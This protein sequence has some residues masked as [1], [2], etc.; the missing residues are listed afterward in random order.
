MSYYL[1]HEGELLE[2]CGYAC[3]FDT[4]IRHGGQAFSFARGAFSPTLRY[5]AKGVRALVDHR[6]AGEWACTRDGSLRLWQDDTGLAFSANIPNT[7]AGRGL[8]RAVADGYIGCSLHFRP[9]KTEETATGYVVLST[10][11]TEISITTRPAFATATWL[12]PFKLM[13]YMPDHAVVLRR[14]LI[15]GQLAAKREA[16]AAAPGPQARAGTKLRAPD[17]LEAIYPPG[18]GLSTTELEECAF[19][20]AAARRARQW[21][22]RAA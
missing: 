15:G 21:S 12:A 1:Q 16:R 13:N 3:L 10:T 20:E 9:F 19:Q 18:L 2:I 8:A 4:T 11:L 14:H 6:R 5:N 22:R 7:I 17:R